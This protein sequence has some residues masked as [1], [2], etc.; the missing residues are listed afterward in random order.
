MQ[1]WI[2]NYL[3]NVFNNFTMLLQFY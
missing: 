2:I 3:L 1:K